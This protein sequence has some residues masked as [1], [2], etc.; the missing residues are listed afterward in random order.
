MKIQRST[1]KRELDELRKKYVQ[2]KGYNV[3]EKYEC[4]QCTL[5]KKDNIVE[6]LLREFFPYKVPLTEE[7]HLEENNS[8]SLFGYDHCKIEVRENPRGAFASF[9]LIFKDINVL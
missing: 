2:E 4:N 6:Q 5:Y 1:K 3:I 9:P 7:K 8:G